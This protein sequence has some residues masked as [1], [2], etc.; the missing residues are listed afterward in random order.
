MHLNLYLS[1]LLE[2]VT[3]DF[4]DSSCTTVF[5]TNQVFSSRG[6]PFPKANKQVLVLI[7]I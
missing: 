6:M 4:D 7:A 1:L 3:K 2:E 5:L